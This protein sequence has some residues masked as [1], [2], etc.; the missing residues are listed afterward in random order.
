MNGKK[1][2]KVASAQNKCKSKKRGKIIIFA[3]LGAIVCLICL[4][5]LFFLPKKLIIFACLFLITNSTNSFNSW[6]Q[7]KEFGVMYSFL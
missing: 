1:E 7:Q 2:I 6:K 5:L 4:G 3:C